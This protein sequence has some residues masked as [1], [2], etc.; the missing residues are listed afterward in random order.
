MKCVNGARSCRKTLGS[1]L[2]HTLEL[3]FMRLME[4]VDGR[5]PTHERRQWTAIQHG[6]VVLVGAGVG[7]R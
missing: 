3:A 4:A 2:E 7:G 1:S 5:R 6:G